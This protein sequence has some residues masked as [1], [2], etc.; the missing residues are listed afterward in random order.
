MCCSYEAPKPKDVIRQ[1][2][3]GS[4][5]SLNRNSNNSHNNSITNGTNNPTRSS[6]SGTPSPPTPPARTSSNVV[7]GNTPVLNGYSKDEEIERIT[8]E[9]NR[10]KFA[11]YSLPNKPRKISS[12]RERKL[13]NDPPMALSRVMPLLISNGSS[14]QPPE[15][16]N[17]SN[18]E[19]SN[20]S[21]EEATT[22]TT[23][24]LSNGLPPQYPNRVGAGK[25]PSG[26]KLKASNNFV[27]DYQNYNGSH[28]SPSH[29]PSTNGVTTTSN[30]GLSS[31][32]PRRHKRRGGKKSNNHN[33]NNSSA[34]CVDSDIEHHILY[35]KETT[36]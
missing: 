14:F 36:L 35:G 7:N 4:K 17:N 22:T 5:N 24:R 16:E 21:N 19:N 10:S 23:S 32:V 18:E 12:Q 3:N 26:H 31:S 27:P 6:T 33:E 29:G 11:I 2:R 15:D 34:Y 25:F 30:E 20:H 9:D 13:S 1:L 28:D 8:V